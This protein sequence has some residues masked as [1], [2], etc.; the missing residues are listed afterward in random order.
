[1]SIVYILY[2]KNYDSSDVKIEKY[3]KESLTKQKEYIQNNKKV[4]D[5]VE[6]V[7]EKEEHPFYM[8]TPREICSE[9]YDFI[10]PEYC[11]IY[12]NR[13][14]NVYQIKINEE[15]AR[16][17][18]YIEEDIDVENTCGERV[19][20]E[21]R[22]DFEPIITECIDYYH[23]YYYPEEEDIDIVLINV[24]IETDYFFNF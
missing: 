21:Y 5:K 9:F 6:K 2:G 11:F 12:F 20:R 22:E 18:D 7:T 3:P 10:N 24:P 1:M 13:C 4:K 14:M 23:A 19:S 17:C 16:I 8:K 15:V